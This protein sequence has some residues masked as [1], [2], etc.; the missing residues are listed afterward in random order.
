[1]V[2]VVSGEE[3]VAGDS[4]SEEVAQNVVRRPRVIPKIEISHQEKIE[5]PETFDEEGN[6]ILA[7]G[8][9]ITKEAISGDV[10]EVE[11]PET[12]SVEAIPDSATEVKLATGVSGFDNPTEMSLS[13]S[14]DVEAIPDRPIIENQEINIPSNGG[15]IT[16]INESQNLSDIKAETVVSDI[17][18]TVDLPESGSIDAISDNPEVAVSS[19]LQT[20]IILPENGSLE[21]IDE[22]K[23]SSEV[24]EA[25]GNQSVQLPESGSISTV[26]NVVE[27]GENIQRVVEIS[28]FNDYAKNVTADNIKEQVADGLFANSKEFA[29]AE[30]FMK[31]FQELNKDVELSD[32]HKK[33]AQ[34][35]WEEWQT[36]KDGSS[37]YQRIIKQ[38]LGLL[39]KQIL[40]NAPPKGK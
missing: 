6:K 39:E 34:R 3:V 22:P 13:E 25:T 11:L 18:K 35:I 33:A 31:K 24:L 37:V 12:G 4:Q 21:V 28:N 8:R 17:P 26:E 7:D 27:G 9:L 19:N 29:T 20:E 10:E 40:Y 16:A 5:L 36:V 32:A 15:E 23:P 14:G 1:M 38:K 30:S 2:K